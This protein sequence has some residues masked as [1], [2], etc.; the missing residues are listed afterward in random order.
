[1]SLA[2]AY[3]RCMTVRC[4]IVALCV[5]RPLTAQTPRPTAAPVAAPSVSSI[6]DSTFDARRAAEF[7]PRLARTLGI[8]PGTRVVLEGGTRMVPVMEALALEARRLGGRPYILLRTDRLQRFVEQELSTAFYA[9]PPTA[10]D[11]ARIL[12][13][14]VRIELPMVS[15]PTI[16]A[17]DRDSA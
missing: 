8:R 16:W 15:D 6:A 13:A 5:A 14:D 17:S 11:S 2:L 12:G 9:P 7:A 10:L 4:A 1:M 3:A